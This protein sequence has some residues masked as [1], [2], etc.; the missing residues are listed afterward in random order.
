MPRRDEHF[1]D[2]ERPKLQ[3]LAQAARGNQ[4]KQVRG[5]LLAIGILLMI[6]N[7]IQLFM[8]PGEVRAG[9]AKQG[10]LVVAPG[11]PDAE[12]IALVLS[13]SLVGAN[14]VLAIVFIVLGALVQHYPVPITIISLG[15]FVLQS[16][17][18]F[19]FSLGPGSVGF[20]VFRVIFIIALVK[21]VRTA[22]AFQSEQRAVA[23][24]DDAWADEEDE[25]DRPRAPKPPERDKLDDPGEQ[26]I[27]AEASRPVPPR[28]VLRPEPGEVDEPILLGEEHIGE[29]H[30]QAS[31]PSARRSTAPTPNKTEPPP[32]PTLDRSTEL[33]DRDF[34]IDLGRPWLGFI[35]ACLVIVGLAITSV[36]AAGKVGLLCACGYVL[37]L[38]IAC[39]VFFTRPRTRRLRFTADGV[40]MTRPDERLAYDEILEIHAPEPTGRSRGGNFPIHLLHAKG[41]LTILPSVEA[42]SQELLDFLD[43]QPL[44]ARAIPRVEPILRD[45]L[46][47]QVTVHGQAAVYVYRART[48][49]RRTP[50]TAARSGQWIA[51][52]FAL[53]G[54]G[55][56]V[57]GVVQQR[58]EPMVGIGIGVTLLGGL[59]WLLIAVQHNLSRPSIKDWQ[60]ATL[61]IGPDG[62][63]FVQGT[64]TGELRWR[65]LKDVT[66]G[67]A[68]A[69]ASAGAAGNARIAGIQLQVAGATITIADIYHWPLSHALEQIERYWRGR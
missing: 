30:I 17:L 23:Y 49:A 56:C 50:S 58:A 27:Q 63:A 28:P 69:G 46:K 1:D 24:D 2:E 29:E 62:L 13:Y 31:P 57:L 38:V 8:I 36:V 22:F 32:I 21:A 3:S 44:G 55:L 66:M 12:N 68:A 41:Y 5:T 67:R 42:D 34:R 59:I 51:L 14:I 4:L 52:A 40:E 37:V 6:W 11:M 39:V 10:P 9:L 61:V 64:L 7:V 47:Q 35:I 18:C 53:L 45:F 43:T 20:V 65:E 19:F 54:V 26:G 25:A 48:V 16:V 33:F 15:L 60:K